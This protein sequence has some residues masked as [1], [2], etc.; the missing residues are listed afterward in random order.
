M[1]DVETCQACDDSIQIRREQ[2]TSDVLDWE[3]SRD[4]RTF[5]VHRE[6]R[7]RFWIIVTSTLLLLACGND[8]DK[9]GDTGTDTPV[10]D[11]TP[12]VEDMGM[13]CEILPDVSCKA[14]DSNE[15]V[16]CPEGYACSGLSA[17]WCYKGDNCDLPI[18]LPSKARIA[19]PSGEV[20]VT[21][22]RVGMSVW[23][24]TADGQ[25]VAAPVQKLGSAVAPTNHQMMHVQLADGRAFRASPRH[26][27]LNGKPVADLARNQLY[28]GASVVTAVLEPYGEPRTFDLLPARDT[29]R[30][31]VNGVLL[32]STLKP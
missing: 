8:E 23:T 19:T 6:N 5:S 2:S 24:Q 31:W 10:V 15:E 29:G 27:G 7:M 4:T 14:E 30:Y 9:N 13:E 28:D 12:V 21:D 26:P 3:Y 22:L 1:V 11:D 17:Y 20:L 32:G 16:P 18:C 25:R